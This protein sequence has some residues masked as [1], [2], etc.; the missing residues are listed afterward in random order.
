MQI[1]K[2]RECGNQVFA[3]AKR[4]KNCGAKRPAQSQTMRGI[5]KWGTVLIW[6]GIAATIL[7]VVL[8]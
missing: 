5:A 8:T 7:L 3:G 2:C 1:I 4:C 6:I